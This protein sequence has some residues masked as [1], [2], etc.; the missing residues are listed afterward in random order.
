MK[1]LLNLIVAFSVIFAQAKGTPQIKNMHQ[2]FDAVGG[3]TDDILSFAKSTLEEHPSQGAS[4]FAIGF[5]FT[6]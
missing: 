4:Q 3:T 5:M 6:E 2:I 1:Y